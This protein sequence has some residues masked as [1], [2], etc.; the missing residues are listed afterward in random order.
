MTT[1]TDWRVPLSDLLVDAE[2]IETVHETLASG[3]WSMGPRVG[4]LEDQFAAFTEAPSTRWRSRTVRR[5][6]ILRSSPSGA[7]RVTKWSSRRSTSSPLRT[8]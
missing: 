6:S 8:P 7:G 3:W 5:R 2:L 1:A 4:D